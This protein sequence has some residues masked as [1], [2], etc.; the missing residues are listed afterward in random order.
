MMTTDES[1]LRLEA[2]ILSVERRSRVA[3][4]TFTV[5]TGPEADELARKLGATCLLGVLLEPPSD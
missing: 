3:L 4:V 1:V 5:P 2:H